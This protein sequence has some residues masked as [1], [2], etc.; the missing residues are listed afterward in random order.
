MTARLAQ[1]GETDESQQNEDESG[2]PVTFLVVDDA[3]VDRLIAGSIVEQA[4][5]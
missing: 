4:L 3:A 5:G 1:A 2:A